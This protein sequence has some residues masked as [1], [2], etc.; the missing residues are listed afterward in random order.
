MELDQQLQKKAA[1]IR[2]A[3]FDVDGVLTNGQLHYS[4]NGIESKSFHSQDGLGMK[5]L[6][7]CGITVAIIT[8][9]RSAIVD[10]RMKELGILHVY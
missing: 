9:R 8:G 4:E 3:I 7:R 2:L 5:Y 1:Q 10:Q 6:H